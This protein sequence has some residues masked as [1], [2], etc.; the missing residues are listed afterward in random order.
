MQQGKSVNSSTKLSQLILILSVL[1]I[2][3]SLIAQF[4]ISIPASLNQGRSIAGTLVMILSFFTIQVNLLAGLAMGA[5]LLKPSTL[6]FFTRGYVIAGIALYITIVCL[7]SNTVLLGLVHLTGL[8]LVADKL[9][10]LINPILFVA[11]WL[12]FIPKEKLKWT[13]TLNWLWYPFFYFL[14]TIIRGT[15]NHWYPYPF[16]N[17]DKLGY[18]QV[19]VNSLFI[20]GA[21][22]ILGLLFVAISRSMTAKSNYSK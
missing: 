7:V 13:Q 15:V 18:S 19:I 6:A 3:F 17:A 12:F 8:A 5:L 1:L 14:Y 22:L 9:M 4:C 10:H 20:L 2:W 21:F 11:Y 16:I